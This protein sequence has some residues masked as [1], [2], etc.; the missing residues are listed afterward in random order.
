MLFLNYQKCLCLK[1]LANNI[2]TKLRTHFSINQKFWASNR[3]CNEE[4][5]KYIMEEINGIDPAAPSYIID[6]KPELWA[7]NQI[8]YHRYGVIN[9]NTAECFNSWVSEETTSFPVLP[10][11]SPCPSFYRKSVRYVLQAR[12]LF[13]TNTER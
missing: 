1:H 11:T 12:S 5:F 3:S 6:S 4:K 9:S 13:A 7:N 2:R 8:N 10:S